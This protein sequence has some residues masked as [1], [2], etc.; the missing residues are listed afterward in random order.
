M[1]HARDKNLTAM[2]L[3]GKYDT[4]FSASLD[5]LYCHFNLIRPASG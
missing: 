1:R 3:S 2:I 4:A 5:A